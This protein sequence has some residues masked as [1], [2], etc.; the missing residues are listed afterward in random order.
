MVVGEAEASLDGVAISHDPGD[1]VETSVLQF[2]Q[3]EQLLADGERAQ[4]FGNAGDGVERDDLSGLQGRVE[5]VG[6]DCLGQNDRDIGPADFFEA[7]Q[8]SYNREL[9]YSIVI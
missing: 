5:A 4:R 1:D 3:V 2:C 7:E 9:L 6:A 8:D